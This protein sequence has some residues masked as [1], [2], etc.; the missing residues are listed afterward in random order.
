MRKVLVLGST[1]S[2]GTQALD[3]IR[4]H[5]DMFEAVGVACGSSVDAVEKQV[6]EFKPTYAAVYDETAASDLKVRLADTDVVVLSGMDGILE[7]IRISGAD[8]VVNGIVGMIGIR[9]ML[10]AIE[11][12][13]DVALANK[14]TCVTAGHIIIPMAKAKGVQILPVDSEHS[15]IFQCLQGK[16][17]SR[18]SRLILTASGGPFYEWSE[19]QLNEVTVE[20]ALAHPNWLMGPKVTI[21]SASMVNKGLEVMEAAWLFDMSPDNIEV[22]IQRES[23]IHSAV[24]YEDS[25]IIAQMGPSDMRI[26]IQYAMTYPNHMASPAPKMDLTKLMQLRFGQP[27]NDVF[28][29]LPLA[30]DALRSGGSMPTVYNASNEW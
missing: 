2:I 27:R 30:Y 6:R 24:E 5:P 21:D 26:P 1:G 9:P 23:T 16:A 18:I 4:L 8:L 22:L 10:V 20:K 25:S 15:A 11:E 13:I 7:M 14:E 19:D 17:D 12:G 29:G 3:V 28:R